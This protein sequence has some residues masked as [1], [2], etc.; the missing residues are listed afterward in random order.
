M[1]IYEYRCDDCSHLFEELLLSRADQ[2]IV[3]CKACG[4]GNV[5]KLLSVASVQSA[6]GGADTPCGK[7]C[8]M[9]SMGCQG[10]DSCGFG[11][12]DYDD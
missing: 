11:G 1:P 3:T 6:A 4:S 10:S 5:V 9:E 8:G 12:D 7:S 2:L